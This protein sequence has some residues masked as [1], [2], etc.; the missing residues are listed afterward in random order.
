MP[1]RPF[2][3][4]SDL[5]PA[6]K[7][8]G[9]KNADCFGN[10]LDLIR[11]PNEIGTFLSLVLGR[12]LVVANRKAAR[13]MLKQLPADG[14]LVTLNGEIFYRNGIV[15]GGKTAASARISR[16]RQMQD[17]EA[18]ASK[19]NAELKACD[20]EINTAEQARKEAE[21][22]VVELE[23]ESADIQTQL[24]QV[25]SR[26][27]QVNIQVEKTRRQLDWN[28]TQQIQLETEELQIEKEITAAKEKIKAQQAE[29]KTLA[30][31]LAE[32]S[33]DAEFGDIDNLRADY[34]F[35]QTNMAVNQRAL[36]ELQKRINEKREFLSNT[37]RSI[38]N[39]RNRSEQVSVNLS[40][41]EQTREE[42]KKLEE[43]KSA[44]LHGLQEQID[45]AEAE[46]N[47]LDLDFNQMQ[48]IENSYQS[49]LTNAEKHLT[50]AQM[51]LNHKRDNLEVL[52]RRIEEDFGLVAFEYSENQSG[53]TPL[54][55]EGMVEELPRVETLSPELEESLT[56][57]KGMLRRMGAVNPE[58]QA[59][60]QTTKERYEFL[61]GQVADLFKAEEDL[62][63]ILGD[64]DVLMTS[65]FHK[66]FEKVANEFPRM[67][68][69]LFGGGSARLSMTEPENIHDTGI[70]I[71][72]RLPG[73][74]RTGIDPALGWGTQSHRRGIDFRPAEDISDALLRPR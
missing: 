51:D 48:E 20:D 17:M 29:Q 62:K 60:Y 63:K 32:F 39:N 71:H 74:A 3:R 8:G 73:Q 4:R 13:E 36:N 50:Q 25:S 38:G 34:N 28:H 47:K 68:N 40:T 70:E 6:E 14:R 61:K 26:Q 59:E 69:R 12:T 56:R 22:R 42:K 19:M 65:E 64:L 23:T 53:P 54:P 7:L 55:I 9:I 57:Y 24:R 27:Q 43:E 37:E 11:Y 10:A 72:A 35:H 66:T 41:L 46:L 16:P 5:Q 30:D 52:R 67:F 58:A 21:K 15:I 49:A 18:Q 44:A 2:S 33:K 45:P 1:V 31:E